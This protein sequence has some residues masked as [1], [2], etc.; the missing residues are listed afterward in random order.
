MIVVQP[1]PPFVP[2]PPFFAAQA[3]RSEQRAN[4][5]A[6][7]EFFTTKYRQQAREAGYQRAAANLRKQGVPLDV[8]RRIL[9]GAV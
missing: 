3:V 7:A 5:E 4:S 1:A 2:M 8:A 9:L 6:I